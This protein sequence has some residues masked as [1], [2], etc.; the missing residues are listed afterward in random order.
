MW[1]LKTGDQGSSPWLHSVNGHVGR[2]WWEFD[3]RLGSPEE[4]AEI[5]RLRQEFHNNRFQN[6]HSSDLL[7]RL[8]VK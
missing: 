8:Q 6:K 7:M 3:P 2:Q 4:V 5:E 1:T